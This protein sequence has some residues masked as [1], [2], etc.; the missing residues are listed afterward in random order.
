MSERGIRLSGT[1]SDDEEATWDLTDPD[2]LIAAML[3]AGVVLVPPEEARGV[4]PTGPPR[5]TE[6]TD[7][8]STEAD[9]GTSATPADDDGTTDGTDS[10]SDSS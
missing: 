4:R 8:E 1:S 6:P 10:D 7:V 9:G 5:D 2:Q 3:E